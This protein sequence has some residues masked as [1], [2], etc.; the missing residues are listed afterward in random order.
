MSVALKNTVR[1]TMLTL[2]VAGLSGCGAENPMGPAAL[3][4]SPKLETSVAVM[5]ID[6][7]DAPVDGVAAPTLIPNPGGS[8][9]IGSKTL[10]SERPGRR[11]GR[12]RNH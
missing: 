3:A 12:G 10:W 2:L 1:A 6:E 11:V 8:A 9:T 7:P 4:V 5:P